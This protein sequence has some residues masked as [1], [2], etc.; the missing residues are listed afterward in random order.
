MNLIGAENNNTFSHSLSTSAS[1]VSSEPLSLERLALAAKRRRL[2]RSS[3]AVACLPVLFLALPAAVS[4]S[5]H[6]MYPSASLEYLSVVV[7]PAALITTP[8]LAWCTDY[9]AG[10]LATDVG[11]TVRSLS[12]V[13]LLFSATCGVAL[14]DVTL[15]WL[16]EFNNQ[17]HKFDQ[18]FIAIALSSVRLFCAVGAAGIAAVMLSLCVDRP[19][20][21][22]V[23]ILLLL[24]ATAASAAYIAMLASPLVDVRPEL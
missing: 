1:P 3:V 23:A 2:L 18:H 20:A 14:W 7:W 13:G 22:H 21:R 12:R 8:I 5:I 16:N 10:R 19:R 6:L 15:S 11:R 24:V 17:A 9:A 4:R